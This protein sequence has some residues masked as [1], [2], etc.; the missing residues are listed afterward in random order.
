MF[1]FFLPQYIVI[2]PRISQ[3][4]RT[5]RGGGNTVTAFK[6]QEKMLM[7]WRDHKLGAEFVNRS[8]Y[9]FVHPLRV[10]EAAA[11]DFNRL[12]ALKIENGSL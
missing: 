10:R 1:I 3:N 7:S 2:K 8:I 4:T 5:T 6:T 9:L 12:S 11:K